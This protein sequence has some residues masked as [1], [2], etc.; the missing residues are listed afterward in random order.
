MHDH[1]DKLERLGQMAHPQRVAQIKELR[2]DGFW[3]VED[4]QGETHYLRGFGAPTAS[5]DRVGDRGKIQ[6][7]IFSSNMAGFAWLRF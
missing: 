4:A 5:L 3:I 7:T 2:A 6:Y 1:D